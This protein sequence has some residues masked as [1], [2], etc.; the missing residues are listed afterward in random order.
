MM[1]RVTLQT[2]T[3]GFFFRTAPHHPAIHAKSPRLSHGRC[4][5]HIPPSPVKNGML[6]VVRYFEGGQHTIRVVFFVA[7][8]L[9]S[10]FLFIALSFRA[11]CCRICIRTFFFSFLFI[12][13]FLRVAPCD[14][15][16]HPV[17]RHHAVGAFFFFLFFSSV[18]SELHK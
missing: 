4:S 13:S 11:L 2:V 3:A 16:Q 17:Y 9:C 5:L 6:C 8:M 18:K 14:E 10:D 12:L 15:E 1:P 7:F